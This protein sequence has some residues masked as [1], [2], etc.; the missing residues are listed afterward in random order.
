MEPLFKGYVFIA[1][2]ENHKWDIK[3]IDGILNYVYW[4]GKPAVVKESEINTIRKFL[5][6]FEDCINF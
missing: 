1:T 5:A 2:D 4:L 3:K 6:E